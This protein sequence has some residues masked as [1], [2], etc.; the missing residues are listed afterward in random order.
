M[1][2]S[3]I[4]ELGVKNTSPTSKERR[5]FCLYSCKCGNEIIAQKKNV[6]NGNTQSCGCLQKLNTSKARKT[7]GVSHK[8]IYRIYYHMKDRCL[9]LKNIQYRDWGGRG[10]KICDEWST[11]FISFYKW[12]MDNGYKDNLQIDRIDNNGDYNPSNCRWVEKN[13]QSRNTRR[14]YK[15]NTS[16]YRGVCFIKNRNKWKSSICVDRQPFH[17]GYFDT[18]LEAAEAYD[19]YVKENKLEHTTNFD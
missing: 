9:N 2:L 18:P 13:I 5:M 19:R 16:G 14:I 11:N 17:L 8:R 12:S 4:K 1:F 3:F 6:D 10:I 15:H 7:H